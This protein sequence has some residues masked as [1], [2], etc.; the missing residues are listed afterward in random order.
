VEALL[1]KVGGSR[2]SL[3]RLNLYAATPEAAAAARRV[4][5]ERVTC[6]VSSVVG[7]L[8]QPGTLVA[9]DAVAVATADASPD[10]ARVR[11]LK[12][13]RAAYVS[14][15][16]ADGEMNV[17]ATLTLEKLDG[18]LRHLKL[19]RAD[20]VHV[21]AFVRGG[22]AEEVAAARAAIAKFFG[23]LRRRELRRMDDGRAD[24]D[25]ARRAGTRPN[26]GSAPRDVVTHLNPPPGKP[27]PLYSRVAV[28]H[29]GRPDLHL[30][31]LAVAKPFD[32]ARPRRG[33]PRRHARAGEEGRRD[34]EHLAKATYYPA[35]RETAAALNKV[36]P[37]FF[38][39]ARPPAA[40]KAPA[41]AT[42]TE[43]AR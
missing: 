43:H 42:G 38:N 30:G 1:A 22:G 24:R 31:V 15:M 11:L 9:L 12:G 40:S 35:T 4:L 2:D 26:G 3:V 27:S 20:V 28:V 14:G 32:D 18:V 6:A 17:A 41:R 5:G 36:R 37:E 10:A 21:K 19:A 25:R 16:A 7:T 39:P 29:G 34:F 13:G 8:P 33:R 23:D